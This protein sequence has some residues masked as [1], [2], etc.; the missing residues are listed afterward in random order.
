MNDAAVGFQC[1]DC[2]AEGR[3][4]TRS[5]RTAY[6]GLRPTNASITSF[7]LIGINAV[8]WVAIMVTGG[9]SSRWWTGW[10]CDPTDC[11]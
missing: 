4:T 5:G 6:G 7:V 11:A 3:K 8:V 10:R 9:G 1:P 2:V